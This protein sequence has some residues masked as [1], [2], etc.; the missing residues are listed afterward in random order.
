[1]YILCD[2]PISAGVAEGNYCRCR[3]LVDILVLVAKVY[4]H[5]SPRCMGN[6]LIYYTVMHKECYL[7]T[8]DGPYLTQA[9]I[10]KVAVISNERMQF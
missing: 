8:I 2:R 9:N 10:G 7:S 5:S 4:T 3:Y 6:V 1:M